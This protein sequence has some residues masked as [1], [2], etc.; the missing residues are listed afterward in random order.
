MQIYKKFLSKLRQN[1]RYT[2]MIIPNSTDEIIRFSFSY[3]SLVSLASSSFIILICLI[4]LSGRFF[5]VNSSLSITRK[6]YSALQ[7]E[8]IYQQEKIS[9]LSKISEEVHN[10][11]DNLVKLEGQVMD[12]VGLE[13]NLAN[14]NHLLVSRSDFR[15]FLPDK[16]FEDDIDL[17]EVLVE[18][19]TSSMQKLI[20]DVE[21]QLAHLESV[22]NLRPALGRLTS[23][24]GFR[25]SPISRRR[26]FHKG[27]DIANKSNSDIYSSAGGV[28][29]FSGYNGSYGRMIMISHGNGY[30][31]VYAHNSK[32]LV[33]VGDKVD[34]G[35][36][37]AKIGS[38]GRSTGPHLH[39]EIR[40]DGKPINPNN[41]L[42]N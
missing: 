1:K 8:N 9:S 12:L 16:N 19:Q 10:K 3:K 34:K 21:K 11:L 7:E 24:F 41:I 15:T 27:I 30:T 40:L 13:N 39:F 28:V 20:V 42:V 17:L 6:N 14:N 33:S 35:D 2:F 38:T 29:T 32:N 23:G 4:I 37:I 18:E 31:T 26:E 5:Y 36:T 25:I 22:P